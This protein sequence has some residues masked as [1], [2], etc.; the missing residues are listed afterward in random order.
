MGAV[1]LRIEGTME[2]ENINLAN[3][4]IVTGNAGKSDGAW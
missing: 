3:P 4:D 2:P 1:P